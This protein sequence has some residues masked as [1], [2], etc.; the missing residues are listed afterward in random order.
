M[1]DRKVFVAAMSTAVLLLAGA[2]VLPRFFFFFELAK[3]S[4][5]FAIAALVYYAEDRYGYM[6]GMIAPPVWFLVDWMSGTLSNDFRILADYVAGRSI[7]PLETPLHGLARLAAIALFI[8]SAHA[9]R[10]EVPEKVF[11]KTFWKGL[12]ASLV[13]VGALTIWYFSSFSGGNGAH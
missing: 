8:A 9:W 11:G 5:Y 1:A 6:L 12:A 7:A 2:F 4:I 3:S 10:K 13:Y